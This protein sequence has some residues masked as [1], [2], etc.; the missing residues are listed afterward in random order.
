[1]NDIFAKM[2]EYHKTVE[3]TNKRMIYWAK[4]LAE[5]NAAGDTAQAEQLR[6]KWELWA[7]RKAIA[8]SNE[9]DC[10]EF[11]KKNL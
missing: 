9:K 4:R 1:M 5:A 6:Y 8:L 10:L 7:E 2:N 11:L 3:Y